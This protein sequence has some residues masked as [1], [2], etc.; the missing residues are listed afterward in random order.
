[1]LKQWYNNNKGGEIVDYKLLSKQ[2]YQDKE[3]YEK[4]YQ[5]KYNSE[6][7]YI[8]DFNMSGY[9]SFV[10]INSEILNAITE[11]LKLD[12]QLTILTES[13]PEIA[14]QTFTKKCLIDEIKLTN[15][16]EGVYSTRRELTEILENLITT[17]GQRFNGLVQKYF[18]LHEKSITL[19]DCKDIR[20][21]Y[22]DLCLSEVIAEDKN[23]IPDGE[24][25]RKNAVNIIDGIKSVHNGIYPEKKIIE[26]M[27]KV[28]KMINND[29]CNEFVK[30]AVF[31][32]MFGYIHPFY[33]GNG[34]MDRF[35]SSYLLSKT[36]HPLVGYRIAYT[37]KKNIND[38]YKAFINCNDILNRGDLTSFVIYF[39]T[40]VS[41]AQIDLIESIKD[42][43]QK[44]N[45]YEAEIKNIAKEDYK[46]EQI[47]LQLLYNEL[48]GDGGMN[49]ATLIEKSGIGVSNVRNTIKSLYGKEIITSYKEGKT[50]FYNIDLSKLTQ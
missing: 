27:T 9:N 45:Y 26:Y 25:F 46:T 8:F 5:D 7:T 30:I 44:L 17:K 41:L 14:M 20:L 10:V 16:I 31:H 50:N 36:L 49:I 13:L 11:I 32:Y 23:N 18:L 34:R 48:F 33:D 35:I 43:I 29:S 3:Q 38:Y 19:D 4:I 21:L 37:I 1:M 12:K 42:S 28:L 6:S 24:L 40:L 47:L 22:D 15:E 2:F 39:L